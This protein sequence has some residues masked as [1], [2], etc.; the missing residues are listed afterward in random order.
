LQE[1]TVI[2]QD[3]SRRRFLQQS[4]TSLL[5][6]AVL[7]LSARATQTRTKLKI[8]VSA[9]VLITELT[10][11]IPELL[12][13]FNVPGLSI[14]LIR[15]SRLLWSKGFG[16][17]SVET[18]EEVMPSTV[19]EAASLSKPVFAYAVLKL[20]ELGVLGLDTPLTTY[21][22]EPFIPNEPRLKLITARMVLSH[23]SGIPHG[24]K[25]G[26]PLALRFDPG[27]QFHY[28]A[29]GFAYL[30]R[31]VEHI[32]GQSLADFMRLNLLEPF[33]MSN[34]SF[35]WVNEYRKQ[36]AQGHDVNSKPGQTLN[37]RYRHF[38]N[39][40]KKELSE[41]YPEIKIPSASAGLYSTPT[42]F[43]KF[44]LR[45]MRPP[46]PDKYHLTE[47]TIRLMLKPQI[48]AGRN[49]RWGL[50]W[51][52]QHTEAGEAFWHWGNLEVFQNVA[53]GFRKHGIGVVIMTNSGN[54]LKLCD[55]LVPKAIGTPNPDF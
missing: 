51:G 32:S 8:D 53:V 50:G 19:F 42:D 2:A 4:V 33:E 24:H 46:Y 23:S 26:G 43:A 41:Q 20:S 27:K 52:I 38:T 10:K 5:Y 28:S 22:S 40:Q 12:S 31:V 11:H 37:E 29:N 34:S 25:P 44:M 21:L 15:D 3:L 39:S 35:G 55:E 36:I 9:E 14:F 49:T 45:I 6:S 18:K 7:P 1:Q 54:G 30:Q 48:K 47:G 17:K 13:R 16:I